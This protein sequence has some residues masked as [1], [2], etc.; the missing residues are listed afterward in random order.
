M[1]RDR[2]PVFVSSPLY[3]E[4]GWG[5]NHHLSIPRQRTTLDLC[6]LLGWRPPSV[7]RV[8]EMA[9]EETLLR[10][11]EADYLAAFRAVCA[12]GRTTAE[13]RERYG[14]G[15][16]ENPVFRGLYVRAATTVGGSILAARCAL[17]GALAFHPAGGTHHGRPD[18]ASGFCYLNDP[19][20][21]ILT[22][23]DA[24]L[25]RIL[26]V[27]L[28]AHHGDG[29]QDAFA[30]EPRVLTVSVHEAKRWPHTG[31]ADDRGGGNARNFPVP[32]GF[33]DAALAALLSGSVMPVAAGFEPEG[34]VVVCGA[35]ALAGD[36]LSGMELSNHALWGAV[37][38]VVG[39]SPV[40]VVLGGGGEPVLAGRLANIAACV[41]VRKLRMT[42][43]ATP[44][45]ILALAAE[46]HSFDK[47]N[48][49]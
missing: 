37:E 42:G 14:L 16:M 3:R 43:T 35:D 7:R 1:S 49:R 9:T 32:R 17:D 19:V 39:L 31:A 27:D 28:D 25:E 46:Y 20:F 26:Y 8:P 12:R 40:A 44:S 10:F 5:T 45:E 22:L 24:G 15:T 4:P 6:D 29:V 38:R 23:L 34:V 2:A 11:H 47:K 18:R 33:D 36:P 21:A 41:T 48:L 30:G 13:A